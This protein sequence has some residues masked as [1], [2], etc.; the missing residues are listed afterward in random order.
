MRSLLI[1]WLAACAANPKQSQP[2]ANKPAPAAPHESE[3]TWLRGLE[4]L[5]D[6]ICTCATRECGR[7]TM[8]AVTAYIDA[9]ITN[10]GPIESDKV[11]AMTREISS[12]WLTI[13][14]ATEPG[15]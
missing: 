1:I 7:V 12:C 6:E 14:S 2:I 8:R 13:L 10:Q 5:Q 4:S 15:T 11:V 9:R 3:A